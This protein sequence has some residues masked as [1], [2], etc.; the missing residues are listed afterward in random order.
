M[1]DKAVDV[2]KIQAWN[3]SAAALNAEIDC[4]VA[5]ESRLKAPSTAEW[6]RGESAKWRD[7]PGYFLVQYA[8]DA[9]N[10]FGAKLRN[11][12]E[13]QVVCLSKKTCQVT[14]IYPTK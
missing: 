10:G 12:Y 4:K 9:E 5:I 14:K 13:C 7:H 3:S 11:R 6:S 2:V 1:A 8:V